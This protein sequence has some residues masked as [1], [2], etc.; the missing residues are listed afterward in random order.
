MSYSTVLASLKVEHESYLSL[1]DE[2]EH[3][4]LKINNRD[5][6]RKVIRWSPIFKDCLASSCGSRVPLSCVLRED[7]A[8]T[9]DI[10]YPLL[11]N[12]YCG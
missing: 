12:Y 4:V 6:D 3:K 9:D 11:Y 2:A 10:V 7:P 1:K 5:N 8:V